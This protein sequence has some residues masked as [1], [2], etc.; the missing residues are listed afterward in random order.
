MKFFLL[1]FVLFMPHLALTEEEY[2]GKFESAPKLEV[3]N[4]AE[5]RPKFVLLSDFSFNDPNGF[6]WTT[7]K[8]WVVDGA[9]IPKVAWSIVGGPLSGKYLHASIIHDY[10][11][12]TEERTAH[13]TH[14]NFYYGMRANGVP[15]GKATT[16]YWVVRTFGPSWKV[17]KE[18]TVSG[19]TRNSPKR[20]RLKKYNVSPPKLEDQA[21]L[22]MLDNLDLELDLKELD[23]ISDEVRKDY[24]SQAVQK[25][26]PTITLEEMGINE[27]D[28][29]KLL[30]SPFR[31]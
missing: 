31:F 22:D 21:I 26:Y 14:R 30:L 11:C 6:T 12:D 27:F 10:Y 8:D 16:M 4:E 2:F 19:I 20:Y 17:V 28:I 7:P 23:S 9:T 24:N 15:K 29:R 13:D 5:G 1:L 18:P 3:K 25:V